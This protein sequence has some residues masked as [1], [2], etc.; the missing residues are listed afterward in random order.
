M[1][2]RAPHAEANSG[3]RPLLRVLLVN[4]WYPPLG[5]GAEKQ[6][7]LLAAAL[8]RRG[9][10]VTVLTARLAGLPRLETIDGVS[11]VRLPCPMVWGMRSQAL[12]VLTLVGAVFKGPIRFKQSLP[13]KEFTLASIVSSV[14]VRPL[15]FSV[16]ISVSSESPPIPNISY[17]LHQTCSTSSLAQAHSISYR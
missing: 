7:H 4:Y 13:C 2:T 12:G 1:I 11:I 15:V 5:D 6:A 17:Q 3:A 8:V 10:A 16:S 14:Y 9:D